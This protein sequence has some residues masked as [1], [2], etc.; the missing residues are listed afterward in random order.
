MSKLITG[1]G[2]I[3]QQG[4]VIVHTGLSGFM[5]PSLTQAQ[6][7]ALSPTEGLFI[8][9]TSKRDLQVYRN[10]KWEN[11][12][13]PAGT[14][15]P[16][17]GGTAPDGW[18]VCDGS[19]VSRTTY[20]DLFS[21]IS[22]TFGT[23]NGSSTFNIPDLRGIFIRGAGSQLINTITYTGTLGTKQTDMLQ[24]HQHETTMTDINF[25]APFGR[26]TVASGGVFN[27]LVSNGRHYTSQIG[28]TETRP[29]NIALNYIIKY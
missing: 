9:N 21:T 12:G 26:G 25:T 17:A 1:S 24:S 22:T 3:E 7:D 2:L 18:M 11:M 14:I 10:G 29:A 6:R 20:S 4:T 19:A 23:G 8:F 15:S 5:L 16:F 27:G 28:G 13:S